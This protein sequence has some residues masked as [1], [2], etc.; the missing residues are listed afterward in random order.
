MYIITNIAVFTI[1]LVVLCNEIENSLHFTCGDCVPFAENE[2][3]PGKNDK[4][5]NS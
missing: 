5:A 1:T 2:Q 3:H 4:D